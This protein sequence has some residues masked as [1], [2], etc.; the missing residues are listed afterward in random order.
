MRDPALAAILGVVGSGNSDFGAD[1]GADFGDDYGYDPN[2]SAM[3]GDFGAEF[4]ADFGDDTE[5]GADFGAAAALAVPPKVELHKAWSHYKMAKAKHARSQ[6]REMMLEPNKGSSVKIERYSFSIN[7]SIVLG[8]VKTLSLTGQPDTNIRPQRVTMNAP[9]P[10]FVI[11][12]EIKVANVAVTVGGAED[13]FNYAAT[14]VGSSLDMPTL[15]PANR[16][17]VLAGYTGFVPPGFVG[18]SAYLF[19]VSFKGPASIIA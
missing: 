18:G 4:G 3:H 14:A 6:R 9:S 1:F 19:A 17:T 11:V 13:A 15:T 10:G 12:N 7:D 8:V 2:A 16:A 5:F